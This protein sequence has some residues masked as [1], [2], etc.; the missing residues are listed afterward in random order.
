MISSA[1]PKG[2]YEW[3]ALT[4]EVQPRS[5]P[6]SGD[7]GAALPSPVDCR[8]SPFDRFLGD[9][10]NYVNIPISPTARRQLHYMEL[11][12]QDLQEP[13]ASVRG[14]GSTKYA[15]ID[16]TATEAAQ[17]VGAQHALGREERLQELEQRRRGANN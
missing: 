13:A 12:L 4:S 15:Q 16:I 14:G 5:D 1:E 6:S 8:M 2:N 9:S 7:C 11:D 10:V 17:R 3:M